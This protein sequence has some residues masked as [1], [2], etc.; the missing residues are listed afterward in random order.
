MSTE[1]ELLN[2]F[3]I[4]DDD[5]SVVVDSNTDNVDV[6]MTFS[7]EN[8]IHEGEKLTTAPAPKLPEIITSDDNLATIHNVTKPLPSN[9][10]QQRNEESPSRKK[11]KDE[12]NNPEEI[13]GVYVPTNSDILCGQSRICASHPGNRQFQGILEDF[14][15]RYDMA[16]SKQNKMYMT[17]EVVA[18]I[19]DIGGRFL[20]HKDGI[21]EE[22]ST[23]AARDKVSH[24]LRTKVASKKKQQ[25]QLLQLGGRD[26]SSYN[27]R[28]VWSPCGRGSIRS[29]HRRGSRRSSGSSIPTTSSDIN[30]ISFDANDSSPSI[31]GNLMQ[32]QQEIYTELTTP[33]RSSTSSAPSST[34]TRSTIYDADDDDDINTPYPLHRSESMPLSLIHI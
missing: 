30:P 17:K 27:R 8:T 28:K 15:D 29:K 2:E 6:A 34:T 3:D 16:T 11:S 22:I 21:W 1:E 9:N 26:L 20:K 7:A 10:P 14:A 32:A 12:T 25:Q 18:V 33:V 5:R 19:H 13:A 4:F 24:A 31:V 23:V